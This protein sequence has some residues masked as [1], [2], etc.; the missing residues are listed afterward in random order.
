LWSLQPRYLVAANLKVATSLSISSDSATAHRARYRRLSLLRYTVVF[1]FLGVFIFFS[2]A[3][4]GFLTPSNL[5]SLLVNNFGILAI[6]SLGMTFVISSGGIDLSVGTAIDIAS[7][8]FVSLVSLKWDLRFAIVGGCLGAAAVGVFNAFLIAGL[9]ITPFLATLGTLFIG[10]S[11]QQ[12]ACN[13][14]Q[15]I[16]LVTGAIPGDFTFIGR[17]L[18]YG[19]PF[20]LIVDAFGAA[21]CLLLLQRS[22]HGRQVFALGAQPGVVWYSGVPVKRISALVYLL[23]ALSGGVAGIILSST[24]KAYVPLSGNAYLLDSIGATFIGT[25]L[26]AERRPSIQGTLLGVLLLSIVTN[27]LLLIGWNFYW[28]Q[29]GTGVLIFLVLAISFAGKRLR[30]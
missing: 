30:R 23:C 15:P 4:P 14:G 24:V 25:T 12:L 18:L 9:R 8:V 22:P 19:V 20:P 13:G 27:G 17:G 7:L 28:Q 6:V 5:L 2:A 29:V 10:Q 1:A 3:A 26:H 21:I 16:Y 11:V